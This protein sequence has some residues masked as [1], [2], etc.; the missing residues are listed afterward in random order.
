MEEFKEEYVIKKSSLVKY[1][2]M[3]KLEF[4]RKE[5]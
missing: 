4:P 3:N 1:L 2:L 5:Q